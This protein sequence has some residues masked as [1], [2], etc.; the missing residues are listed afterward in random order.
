MAETVK[1]TVF[2]MLRRVVSSCPGYVDDAGIML[3]RKI[4]T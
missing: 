4:F 1:F 2:G 3:L